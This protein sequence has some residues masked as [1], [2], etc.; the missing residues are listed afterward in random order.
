MLTNGQQPESVVP[1]REKLRNEVASIR[2]RFRRATRLK[3]QS[4]RYL[5]APDIARI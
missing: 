3:M 4:M 1:F 2:S 5:G